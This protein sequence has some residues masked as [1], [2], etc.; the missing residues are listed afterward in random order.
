[1]CGAGSCAVALSESNLDDPVLPYEPLPRFWRRVGA[2]AGNSHHPESI[3]FTKTSGQ[4]SLL[5]GERATHDLMTGLLNRSRR[6]RG[7]RLVTSPGGRREGSSLGILF[8]DLD[9]LKQTNDPH[10]HEAGGLGQRRLWQSS[11]AINATTRKS[12]V[13][14]RLGGDEFI[15]GRLGGPNPNGIAYTLADPD[16]QFEECSG[17]IARVGNISIVVGCSIG[18][19]M[20][21]STDME[22]D[23]VIHRADGPLRQ[24]SCIHAVGPMPVRPS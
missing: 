10:G 7:P 13:V 21:E 24:P 5:L 3:R 22:I 23:S 19:A 15:V 12:D 16:P 8:I 20:S 17:Q 14:G 1:M 6:A 4:R 9:G 11:V 2:I 18:I